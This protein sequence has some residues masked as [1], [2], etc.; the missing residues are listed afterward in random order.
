VQVLAWR[1][2]VQL[3]RA[4]A[5]LHEQDIVHSDLKPSNLLLSHDG[6][7]KLCDLGAAAR[8]AVRGRTTLVGSPAYLAPEVVAID[9]LGLEPG[10]ATYGTPSDIWSVGVLLVEMLSG[11][12]LPFPAVPRDPAAQPA[13]V[14]FRPPILEP[15]SAFPAPARSLVM[16]L[17]AKQGYLRPSAEEALLACS[18]LADAT[19][20]DSPPS[21]REALEAL[22]TCMG[23]LAESMC[24]G[25][26]QRT[27]S[28]LAHQFEGAQLQ[29]ASPLPST[30]SDSPSSA[31]SWASSLVD[32]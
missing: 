32:A 22:Q 12:R 30:S 19:S 20:G 17:L 11:G 24:V 26:R 7:L 2:V 29:C 8:V 27:M 18:G 15:T 10:G 14:C 1:L 4:L 3:L 23:C 9:H 28:A 13:A 16:R 21:E 31:A 25:H 6:H 5:H